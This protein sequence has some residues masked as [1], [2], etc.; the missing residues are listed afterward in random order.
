MFTK[1]YKPIVIKKSMEKG[2]IEIWI[3]DNKK[4][5]LLILAFLGFVLTGIFSY[6]TGNP[7]VIKFGFIISFIFILTDL[8]IHGGN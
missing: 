2:R 5:Y 7:K 6:L 1:I 8:S 4:K 3:E